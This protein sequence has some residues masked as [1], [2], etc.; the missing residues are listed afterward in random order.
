MKKSEIKKVTNNELIV[1]Y[2][3]T[4]FLRDVNWLSGRGIKRLSEQSKNLERELIARGILTT[5]DVIYLNR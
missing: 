5:E 2:V 4:Y 1:E 3:R